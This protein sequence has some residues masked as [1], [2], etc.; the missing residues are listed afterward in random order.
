MFIV[1]LS[2]GKKVVG[3]ELGQDSGWNTINLPIVKL[4]YDI[5]GEKIYR[6]GFDQY[7]HLVE[8]NQ[9]RGKGVTIPRI[10]LLTTKGAKLYITEINLVNQHLINYQTTIDHPLT[11]TTGWKTGIP[12]STPKM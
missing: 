12:L 5:F 3:K 6:E 8:I 10:L 11:K 4:E 1:T 2:N 7:N 9:V